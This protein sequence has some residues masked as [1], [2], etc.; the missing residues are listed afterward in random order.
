MLLPLSSAE[1]SVVQAAAGRRTNKDTEAWAESSC[2]LPLPLGLQTHML[3]EAP[4][5]SRT[6]LGDRGHTGG[7]SAPGVPVDSHLLCLCL[8]LTSQSLLSQQW[9]ADAFLPGSWRCEGVSGEGRDTQAPA[10]HTPLAGSSSY[11]RHPVPA[12][13][14]AWPQAAPEHGQ[15]S[16][17]LC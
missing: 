16:L 2:K 5:S 3:P 17:M 11:P 12:G 4:A 14:P 6:G 10:V 7:L 15:A 8:S 1:P 13:M 9:S